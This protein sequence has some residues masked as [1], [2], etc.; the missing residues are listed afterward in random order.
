[1]VRKKTLSLTLLIL[2]STL[3]FIQLG[4]STQAICNI[5]TPQAITQNNVKPTFDNFR[6]N[7]FNESAE[8]QTWFYLNLVVIVLI[9]IVIIVQAIVDRTRKKPDVPK[10]SEDEIEDIETNVETSNKFNPLILRIGFFVL[11]IQNVLILPMLIGFLAMAIALTFGGTPNPGLESATTNLFRVFS[12]AYYLDFTAAVLCVV[13]LILFSL[14]IKE[15]VLAYVASGFWL[16]WIGVSIYPRIDFVTS[17]EL[18]SPVPAGGDIFEFFLGF[19]GNTTFLLTCG[20]AALALGLFYTAKVLV[21]NGKIQRGGLINA[22]GLVNFTIGGFANV[23]L[24][25]LLTWGY[26]MDDGVIAALSFILAVFWAMK[27]LASPILGLVTGIITF[28]RIGKL[29]TT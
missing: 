23:L 20:Y 14:N 7:Q 11:F 28:N 18:F 27:F 6:I 9:P 21:A 13:G 16:L 22:F 29:K 15:K 1:M 4:I 19:F 26:Q 2:F 17:L 8:P 25:T 10:I 24:L 3:I 12:I 5:S